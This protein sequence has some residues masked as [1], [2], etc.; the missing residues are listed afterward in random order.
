MK[1]IAA[2]ALLAACI[3]QAWAVNK[4]TVNGQIVY[5]DKPCEG[6][7]Q[8]L[9][10]YGES[11]PEPTRKRIDGKPDV[12]PNT[13]LKGPV[14]SEPMLDLYRR[15]ADAE[16]L[17]MSSSRIALAAP[18]ANMQA[19]QREVEAMKVPQCLESAKHELVSLVTKSTE[20]ILQFMGKDDVPGIVYQAV[21]KRKLIPA[22]EN[23]VT[24]ANCR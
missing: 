9:K 7:G 19:I 3:G 15:W 20:A 17:A 13:N 2:I 6:D 14:G 4:C 23:A 8:K 1:K 5:S 21:D 11:V 16:R 18:A 22:F 10:I 24:N 12:N